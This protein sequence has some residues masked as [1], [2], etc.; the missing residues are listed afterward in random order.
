MNGN[1]K[2]RNR[3]PT[4]RWPNRR[5]IKILIWGRLQLIKHR[6]IGVRRARCAVCHNIIIVCTK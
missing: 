1:I 4:A 3:V 6:R 5:V 2:T